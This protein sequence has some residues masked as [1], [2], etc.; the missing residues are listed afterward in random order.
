MKWGDSMTTYEATRDRILYLCG[1]QNLSL[2]RLAVQAALPPSSVKNI[3]YGKSTNPTLLTIKMICDGFNISL[4]DF[5][6]DPIFESI[7]YEEQKLSARPR[8]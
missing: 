4:R 1:K 5:F 3:I 6:E 8:K 2:N 7:D